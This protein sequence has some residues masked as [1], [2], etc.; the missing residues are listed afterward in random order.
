VDLT[1]KLTACVLGEAGNRVIERV[2]RQSHAIAASILVP[3]EDIPALVELSLRLS[4]YPS[5]LRRHARVSYGMIFAA[6]STTPGRISLCVHVS[7][8]SGIY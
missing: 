3:Y 5:L 6:A 4:C 7:T 1:L 8:Y 2:V